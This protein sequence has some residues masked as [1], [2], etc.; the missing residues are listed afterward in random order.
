M[1]HNKVIVLLLAASTL[2]PWRESAWAQ[3]RTCGRLENRILLQNGIPVLRLSETEKRAVTKLFAALSPDRPDYRALGNALYQARSPFM[4][5]PMEPW[6]FL[7]IVSDELH[8]D[9]IPRSPSRW[10]QF[11]SRYL[12]LDCGLEALIR[13]SSAT[14]RDLARADLALAFVV[15]QAPQRSRLESIFNSI[16]N[17]GFGKDLTEAVIEH[18]LEEIFNLARGG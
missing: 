7:L 18:V 4:A 9:E 15:V 1:V 14:D 6:R 13:G 10:L 16:L 8:R 5:P 2:L 3:S 11:A 12:T 17:R